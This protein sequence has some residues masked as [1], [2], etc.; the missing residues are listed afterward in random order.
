[1]DMTC[2]KMTSLAPYKIYR[3]V[4]PTTKGSYL[5]F[6]FRAAPE[7]RGRFVAL[8]KRP[9]VLNAAVDCILFEPVGRLRAGQDEL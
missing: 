4:L 6:L 7:M 8:R 3:R 5:M 9:T 1:M 2:S